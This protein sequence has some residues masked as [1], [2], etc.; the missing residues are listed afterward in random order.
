MTEYNEDG[1][2]IYYGDYSDSYI[3]F[4][5]RCGQGDEYDT[6]GNSVIYS[7]EWKKNKRNGRGTF[8]SNRCP[9]YTGQWVDGLPQG[10]GKLLDMNGK[11]LH[12]GNWKQGYLELNNRKIYFDENANSSASD[13]PSSQLQTLSVATANEIVLTSLSEAI[14]ELNV[15]SNI[16]NSLRSLNFTNCTH[17]KKLKIENKCFMFVNTLE[18]DGLNFLQ[19]IDI[20]TN[21][22]TT[23]IDD[24]GD[25]SER[26]L[27]I[28]N[29]SSLREINI[30]CYS[31]SDAAGEFKLQSTA[32]F[33]VAL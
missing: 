32:F 7:G 11:V 6:N 18:I 26:S 23:K 25:N 28:T 33:F 3:L 10:E 20:G 8:F 4:Y 15:S 2:Q 17:L 24:Q 5:P 14:Q 27:Q 22:F 9:H 31:F 30:D 13:K 16:G 1:D 29:C 12:Q 19:S 21:S